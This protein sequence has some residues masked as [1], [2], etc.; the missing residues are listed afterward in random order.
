MKG[1]QIQFFAI[2]LLVVSLTST[3]AQIAV[4]SSVTTSVVVENCRRALNHMQ[5]DC[6][7]YILGVF[8]ELSLSGQICPPVNPSGGSAQA[9]AVALKFLT[10]HPERW[11]L[12]P[13][14]LLREAFET[15]FPCPKNSN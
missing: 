14:F 7:G 4:Q 12:T 11:H 10:E 8:D 5:M 2:T 15:A 13:G 9:V 3:E 1:I 6:A